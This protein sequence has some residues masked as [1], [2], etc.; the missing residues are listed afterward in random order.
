V[1]RTGKVGPEIERMAVQG[2]VAPDVWMMEATGSPV[3]AEPLLRATDL[4]LSAPGKR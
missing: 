2:A 4:A 3:S 1:N